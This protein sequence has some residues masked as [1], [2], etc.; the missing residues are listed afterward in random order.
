MK[1]NITNL[2]T[3]DRT[4]A[5]IKS[6]FF[7]KKAFII[8]CLILFFGNYSWSQVENIP[9]TGYNADVV[10]NGVET[11]ESSTTAALDVAG[12]VLV[13]NDFNPGNG[14]CN[15]ANSWPATVTSLVAPNPVYTLQAANGNNSLR[16]T[17]SSSGTLTVTTPVA[18][19]SVYV[20]ATSGQGA[21][22]YT[23]IVTFS[24]NSTETFAG[25]SVPRLV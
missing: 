12:Y 22:N 13:S 18:C 3:K 7:L 6:V 1:K 16:L 5:K 25:I 11:S 20:L 2:N 8:S 23:A 4:N 19:Q 24:D 14:V 21:G 9:C 15:T 10:A 17:G